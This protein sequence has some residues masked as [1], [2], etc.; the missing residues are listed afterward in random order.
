MNSYP[1]PDLQEFSFQVTHTNG[2]TTSETVA[3]TSQSQ[4][5][6]ELKRWI[7]DIATIEVTL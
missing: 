3:S 7:D 5:I 1:L 6:Q 2:T 4:A